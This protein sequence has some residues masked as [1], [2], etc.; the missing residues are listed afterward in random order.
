MLGEEVAPHSIEPQLRKLGLAT[1]LIRGVPTLSAPHVV[2]KNGD[3]LNANQVQL[4]KLLVKPMA[5]VRSLP[6]FFPSCRQCS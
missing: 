3:K 4:L 1:S 5:T 2:C 6:F